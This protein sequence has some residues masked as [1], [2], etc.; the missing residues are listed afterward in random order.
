MTIG[1]KLMK[2]PEHTSIMLVNWPESH[3]LHFIQR[4][5]IYGEA[6]LLVLFGIIFRFLLLAVQS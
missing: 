6:A 5:V 3:I 1:V 2:L 4:R